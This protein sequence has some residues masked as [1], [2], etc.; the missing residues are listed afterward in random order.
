PDA[1][2]A[3]VSYSTGAF[4][5]H[6]PAPGANVVT[7]P[8]TRM[9][10]DYI[11]QGDGTEQTL[12][13]AENREAGAWAFV[14]SSGNPRPTF[15][16]DQV[17]FGLNLNH[18]NTGGSSPAVVDLRQNLTNGNPALFLPTNL[19]SIGDSHPNSSALVG[20][21]GDAP[22]PSSNHDGI[23]HVTFA[24]G[25]GGQISDSIDR[26]VYLQLLTAN[27]QRNGQGV[28]NPNDY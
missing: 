10:L 9:T 4:W 21:E 6:P 5:R 25:R 14:D 3:R 11:E 7:G 23:I 26:R 13:L 18:P 2:D 28:V 27:G 8:E 12:L 1:N 15:T 22:R 17:G 16:I 19:V 20:R 24:S